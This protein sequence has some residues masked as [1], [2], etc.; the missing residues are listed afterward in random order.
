MS[1]AVVGI[2]SGAGW[3]LASLWCLSRLLRAW[4]GPQRSKRRVIAWLLIKFPALYALA[5]I[6]LQRRLIAP[7]WFG[8][9]FTAA[10]LAALAFFLTRVPAVSVSAHDR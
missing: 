10:L 8:V 3:N 5:F 9:G 7:V 2:V 6:L 4:L 1:D